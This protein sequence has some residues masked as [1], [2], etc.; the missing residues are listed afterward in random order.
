[1]HTRLIIIGLSFVFFSFALWP[2]ALASSGLFWG[3]IAWGSLLVVC[4]SLLYL[5]GPQLALTPGIRRPHYVQ[6]TVQGGVFAY[7]GWHW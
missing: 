5:R 7:W 2:R 6:M 4:L 1:M 3:I